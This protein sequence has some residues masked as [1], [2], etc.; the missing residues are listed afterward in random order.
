[1]NQMGSRLNFMTVNIRGLLGRK[2]SKAVFDWLEKLSADIYFLQ[3][4][5]QLYRAFK[6]LVHSLER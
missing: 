2:K 4:T 6:H 3:E 1:M 5:H